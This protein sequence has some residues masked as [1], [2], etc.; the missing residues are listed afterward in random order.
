M[1]YFK[2]IFAWP[3]FYLC[4]I[5]FLPRMSSGS[6]LRCVVT[7]FDRCSL[8]DLFTSSPTSFIRSHNG[9]QRRSEE[10]LS[11]DPPCSCRG[12]SELCA[13]SMNGLWSASSSGY[14]L[15][16]S[17]RK[18]VDE[19]SKER[20]SVSLAAVGGPGAMIAPTLLIS[21]IG[22]L[23][24]ARI[25]FVHSLRFK[26][27][28]EYNNTNSE[29]CDSRDSSQIEIENSCQDK[30]C[31]R[32]WRSRCWRQE[33][34]EAKMTKRRLFL[35][36]VSREGVVCVWKG[37]GLKSKKSRWQFE[38]VISKDIYGSNWQFVAQFRV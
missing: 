34:D 32:R 23:A 19:S 3:F 38:K 20:H 37:C 13:C 8:M 28:S 15:T 31:W 29:E 9:S 10:L 17:R 35:Y 4:C 2:R 22:H 30:P 24:G 27:N 33:N 16:Y 26:R 1:S 6:P 21:G 18:V 36:S 14:L 5:R 12:V 7:L 25:Y 11:R